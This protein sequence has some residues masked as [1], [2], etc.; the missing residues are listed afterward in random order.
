MSKSF[1]WRALV[2][3]A[4][5]AAGVVLAVSRPVRLGLD[6][7]GGTQIV[8]EAQD[9]PS[10]EVD[11]DTASRTLEVLRRRVDALGVSEPT[12][13]RS[14]ERRIIVELPGVADPEEALAVIGRTAQLSFHPVLGVEGTPGVASESTTTTTASSDVVVLPAE[15]GSLLRLGPAVLTGEAVADAGATFGNSL[16]GEWAV[17]I[18]F[19][20]DGGARFAAL[21]ADAA[22]LTPGDPGRRVAIALDDEVISSPEVATTVACGTGI[23]GGTTVITGQENEAEARDLALLIRAGAL[24]VPVEVVEQRTV[25]PTLGEAAIQA[26]VQAALIGAALTILYMIVAYRLLGALAAVGLAVYG[27]LSFAVLLALDATLTLPG[28]AGFV[29][30]IGMAVDA[31]VLVFERAK[32]EH[33]AGRSPRLAATRGFARAWS[34]IADSNATTLLAALLLFF[35]ASGAVR[36]FGITLSVGVVVSMFSA[37]MVTRVLVELTL[38]HRGLS[39]NPKVLGLETGS[40]LRPW[41][42]TRGPA[43]LGRTRLWLTCS[44]LALVLAVAGIAVRGL[45]FG[46]EFSGGRL[47]EYATEQPVDLE[48]L[49][50]DLAAAG[51]PRAVVQASGDENFAIRSADLGA[52]DEARLDD[53]VQ[54]LA[55]GAEVVR[56]EFVGPTIGDELRN[57]ALI[58][59]GVALA[60]Q[61]AYLAVRFR[62]TFGAAAVAAMAHDVVILLGVFAWLGKDLDGVFLAALLTVIGYSI[63]D[64]VVV[65]DRVREQRRGRAGDDLV[66]VANDACL[67][68]IPRTINTGLGA[69]F[70][71]V[72]LYVL[73]G[74]T[75]TDF[76][77]A[78]LIGIVVGTYSSIFTATPVMVALENRRHEPAPPPP[79]ATKRKVPA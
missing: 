78:L 11:D 38:R 62:W 20:G 75:L 41:L 6:L 59:L 69:L 42:A 70:I 76:A 57:K 44:A 55:G 71:L 34:A 58:A 25:G 43:L 56:E 51:L 21:T 45:S 13:Q 73:G 68:T 64:T 10:Q 48:A 67:Q 46:L 40:R 79:T 4:A 33:A 74:D 49:R 52:A 60:A 36:G 3:V 14:G 72:A 39:R 22:C 12:L 8:L 18:D 24:P 15:D 19:Q 26:S 66:V 7:R 65:F 2:V 77:L 29:L 23:T 61:L 31:N 1:R 27:L 50:T 63:N 16:G 54:R 35:F 5:L 9:T 28:I 32:E 37:L 30:A 53:V 47:V 17:E